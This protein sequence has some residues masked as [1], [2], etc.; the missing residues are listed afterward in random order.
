MGQMIEM[1]FFK[2][3]LVYFFCLLILKLKVKADS[4]LARTVFGCF[5]PFLHYKKYIHVAL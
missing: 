3:S 2:A 5:R 1:T 4:F